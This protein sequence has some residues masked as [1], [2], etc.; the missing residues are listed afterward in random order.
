MSTDIISQ[1]DLSNAEKGTL[2]LDGNLD[3]VTVRDLYGRL[4][5]ALDCPGALV[6]DAAQVNRVDGAA[7]QVLVAFFSA[8]KRNG[9]CCI[10][11]AVSDPLREAVRLT[12]LESALSLP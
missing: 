9:R 5:S 12:G 11:S 10:W 7:I 3:I 1:L 4:Q 2:F 6:I 8:A